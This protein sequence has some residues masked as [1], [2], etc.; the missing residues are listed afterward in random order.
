MPY[1][2]CKSFEIE[3]GHMLAQHPDACRFPHGH[4]RSVEFVLEAD[5]LDAHGMV[6]DFKAVSAVIKE[7]VMSFDHALCMNRRDPQYRAFRRAYG[8]R[9]IPFDGDP[10]TETLARH[11]HDELARRLAAWRRRH[12]AAYPVRPGV[13]IVRVRVWETSTSWAEYAPAG[14]A[15]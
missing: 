10:T 7:F 15:P 6:C 5:D 14:G 13:R 2:I 12:R 1:R 9:I 11:F 3:S 8:A 4:S